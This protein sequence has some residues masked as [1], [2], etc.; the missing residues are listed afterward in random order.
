MFRFT[1]EELERLKKPVKGSDRAR[2]VALRLSEEAREQRNKS[3]VRKADGRCRWPGCD[4]RERRDRLEVAHVVN[5]SQGGLSEPGNLIVLCLARHQG[6]PS[7]HSGEL[8]IEPLTEQ[9]TR[10]PCEFW[11]QDDHGWHV[12]AREVAPFIL[13]HAVL[14]SGEVSR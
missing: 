4:C 10:G 2:R 14:S 3:R 8:R 11:Q 6:K 9:G 1:A 13:E 5:K 12:V 7:L